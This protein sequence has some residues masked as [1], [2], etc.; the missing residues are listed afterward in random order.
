MRERAMKRATPLIAMLAM[1]A[2]HSAT[3]ESK[4]FNYIIDFPEGNH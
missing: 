2:A 1:A 3:Y 4:G